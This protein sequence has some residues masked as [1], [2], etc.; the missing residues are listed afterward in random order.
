MQFGLVVA[1]DLDRYSQFSVVP[2]GVSA[3]IVIEANGDT[4]GEPGMTWARQ[5]HQFRTVFQDFAQIVADFEAFSFATGAVHID[6][7]QNQVKLKKKTLKN[8]V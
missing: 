1:A 7:G 8:M 2:F 4:I 3:D 6:F 5:S